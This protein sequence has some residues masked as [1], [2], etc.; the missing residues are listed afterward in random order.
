MLAGIA[1]IFSLRLAMIQ[2]E[3]AT[4]RKTINT[5]KASARMLFV[6]SGP[7]PRCRKKDA[8]LRDGEHD[9]SDRDAR[10]PQQIGLRHD[11]RADRRDDRERQPDRVGQ[12]IGRRLLLLDTG[13]A[14]VEQARVTVHHSA[15]IR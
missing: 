15:P 8:D 9:Q 14:V 11:K 1:I 12:E 3:P 6:F 4:T 2:Q 13:R 5:P 10:R 7:L